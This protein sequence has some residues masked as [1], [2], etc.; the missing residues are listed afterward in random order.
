MGCGWSRTP[1]SLASAVES[2]DREALSAFGDATLFIEPYARRPRH[3]EVQVIGDSHGNVVHLFERECSIQ[4]RH[5]K[6]VEESPSPVLDDATRA[7]LCDAAV[8]AA[9]AIGY[10]NAGT[11]EFLMLEDGSF[12]F[13]EVNTRLQVEHPVTELVTGLDLVRLQ[14]LVAEG[15]EL[16][17]QARFASMHG[18][19]DRGPALRR[20]SDERLEAVGRSPAPLQVPRPRSGAAIRTSAIRVD[21][22][23]EDGTVVSPWYDP[24]LAKVIAFA[25]T[26]SE[27]ARAPC[28]G[29]CRRADPRDHH[30]PGPARAHPSPSGVPRRRHRHRL[31]GPPRPGRARRT[32]RLR[33]GRTAAR[34]RRGPR[35]T[36][37]QAARPRR[38]SVASRRDG[39]T[40]P[41]SLSTRASSGQRGCSRSP[42]GSTA[43]DA[44]SRLPARSS[45]S[46]G[47]RD[48]RRA[49]GSGA[50]ARCRT[51]SRC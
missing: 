9:K 2:A 4:R 24:M 35:G 3:I 15:G 40:T 50:G 6:I 5:Q 39:A 48:R 30:Q 51:V 20:G 27:A 28:V 8:T 22:G 23:V 44:A 13:L 18:S 49:T 31:P 36:G 43:P 10:V 1:A 46:D 26:R 33:R 38:C 37:R 42:T 34:G 45:A 14:L 29:A 25:P 11:V 21:A 41:R 16:P 32:A 12:A 47:G 19:R 7:E 17:E